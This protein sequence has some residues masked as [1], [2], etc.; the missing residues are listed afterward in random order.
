MHYLIINYMLCT[1]YSNYILYMHMLYT[2]INSK[3]LYNLF[4]V[5]TFSCFNCLHFLLQEFTMCTLDEICRHYTSKYYSA[6]FAE[7]TFIVSHDKIQKFDCL[8][9]PVYCLHFQ[10][11]L[12]SAVSASNLCNVHMI[13]PNTMHMQHL[14][15]NIDSLF[16]MIKDVFVCMHM[17]C[18]SLLCR[19][20]ISTNFSDLLYKYNTEINLG[21]NTHNSQQNS[22]KQTKMYRGNHR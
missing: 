16:C 5:C 14:L 20:S 15:R 7:C 6:L 22:T 8:Y 12:L 21:T 3:H 17:L 19:S 13:S 10:L 2:N 9:N 11:F 18:W 4:T 1:L